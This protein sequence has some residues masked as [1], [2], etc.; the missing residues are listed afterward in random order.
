MKKVFFRSMLPPPIHGLFNPRTRVGCD[1]SIV[2]EIRPAV[3]SIR[4]PTRGAG[5][6]RKVLVFF[7]DVSIRAPARGAMKMARKRRTK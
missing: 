7:Q 2:E 5:K 3:V 1:A 6:V 4:A